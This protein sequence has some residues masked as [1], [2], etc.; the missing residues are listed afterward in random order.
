MNADELYF[1]SEFLRW[2]VVIGF[3]LYSFFSNRQSAKQTEMAELTKK[4]VTLEA[5][6]SHIPTRQQISL[7]FER[8]GKMEAEIDGLSR[9]LEPINA[10]LNRINDYLLKHK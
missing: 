1:G 6:L 9:Q 8:L 5:D 10:S 3:A 2:L 4:V 7:L